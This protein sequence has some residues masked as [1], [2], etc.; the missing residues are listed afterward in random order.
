MKITLEQPEYKTKITIDVEQED[1]TVEEVIDELFVPAMI[2]MGYQ[3]KSI[4]KFI[5]TDVI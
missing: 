2:A 4:K 1:L 5:E 3:P